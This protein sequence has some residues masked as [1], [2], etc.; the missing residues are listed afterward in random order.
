MLL[1]SLKDLLTLGEEKII[2]QDS[3]KIFADMLLCMF[4]WIL[5]NVLVKEKGLSRTPSL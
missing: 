3:H 2:K 5:M 4:R 1:V